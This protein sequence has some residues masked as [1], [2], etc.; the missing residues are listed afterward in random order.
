[1]NLSNNFAFKLPLSKGGK[2]HYLEIL[3]KI[4]DQIDAML[5][6]HSKVLVVIVGLHLHEWTPDNE[7]MSTFLRRLKTLLK[8]KKVGLKRVGHTWCREQDASDCQ[9]YHFALIVDGNKFCRSHNLVKLIER[10]WEHWGCFPKPYT[11]KNCYYRI[12]RGCEGSYRRAFT[13]LSYFAKV[14]TKGQRP[15]STNDYSTSRIR[16]KVEKKRCQ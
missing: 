8:A 12:S 15:E 6:H 5:S 16:F 4:K 9:H 14:A 2:G 13:R 3:E 11:P 1:M 7:V 10:T